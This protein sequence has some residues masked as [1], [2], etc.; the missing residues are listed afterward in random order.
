MVPTV[1]GSSRANTVVGRASSQL[2]P[3]G[4]VSGVSDL[5]ANCTRLPHSASS[6]ET[7]KTLEWSPSTRSYCYSFGNIVLITEKVT[8]E[9]KL[10]FATLGGKN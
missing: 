9:M 4:T 6:L 1:S 5:T 8:V 10:A 7:V 2:H 3:G